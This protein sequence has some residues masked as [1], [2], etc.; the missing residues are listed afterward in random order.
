MWLPVRRAPCSALRCVAW[1]D[2]TIGHHHRKKPVFLHHHT[3]RP[4]RL[5]ATRLRLPASPAR[6]RH[7]NERRR[8]TSDQDELR[9]QGSGRPQAGGERCLRS[10][11]SPLGRRCAG[12]NHVFVR[13]AWIP[14]SVCCTTLIF[15]GWEWRITCKLLRGPSTI[16][17]HRVIVI[18]PPHPK[19]TTCSVPWRPLA[20]ST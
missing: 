3:Q 5:S 10:A 20:S 13:L 17:M 19:S 12:E 14:I 4:G 6:P 7:I 8:A 2:G 9:K 1:Y 16:H 11:N 18:S 15:V